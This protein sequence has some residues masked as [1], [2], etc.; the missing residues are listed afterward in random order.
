MQA[1][2]RKSKRLLE[3]WPSLRLTL[4]PG[5]EGEGGGG[6]RTSVEGF[7]GR[8]HQ[9]LEWRQLGASPHGSWISYCLTLAGPNWKWQSSAVSWYSTLQDT[10]QGRKMKT[11]S[12]EANGRWVTTNIFFQASWAL[13][14]QMP[15]FGW[16]RVHRPNK[17]LYNS[18]VTSS[19]VSS[20]SL[21]MKHNVHTYS[22]TLSLSLSD[23]HTLGSAR[24]DLQSAVQVTQQWAAV[25]GKLLRPSRS[26][27]AGVAAALLYKLGSWR[28]SFQRMCW[29]ACTSRWR[30]IFLPLSLCG[31][32]AEG[33]VQIK[34]AHH[35][36]RHKLFSTWKLI[37]TQ[38]SACL[39]LLG[40]KVCATLPGPKLL[41]ATIPQDPDQKPVS[42]SLK[43]WITWSW[44]DGSVV[45]NSALPEVLSSIP[46]SHTVAYNI[47]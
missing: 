42:P 17:V 11:G 8:T 6:H 13:F 47:L 39:C 38:R 45:K 9:P 7:S 20:Q 29:Q 15:Q 35:H 12:R 2:F 40:L 16:V 18:N 31:P 46:S 33:M 41:M 22:V 27:E 34:D 23:T 44:R 4:L 1:E 3:T 21:K 19:G 30:R 14:H 28:S 25:N 36:P 26:H 5:R 37:W 24:D 10:G 32:A 43:V